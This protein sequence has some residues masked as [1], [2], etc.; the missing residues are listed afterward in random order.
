MHSAERHDSKRIIGARQ[1]CTPFLSFYADHLV[2]ALQL[3][4]RIHGTE[5]HECKYL[6]EH[7]VL[8][9][10]PATVWING[11]PMMLLECDR[12]EDRVHSNDLCAL[13]GSCR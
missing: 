11:F 10:L 13:L 8:V 9:D 2:F 1:E 4:V 12:S 3:Q 5:K 6:S 7:D